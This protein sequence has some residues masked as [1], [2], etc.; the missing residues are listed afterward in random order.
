VRASDGSTARHI[1]TQ[2]DIVLGWEPVRWFNA[3][4]A[5]SAFVP[6]QFIRDTGPSRTTHFVGLEAS[7]K[8]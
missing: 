2:F 8:F 3:E 1:G 4:L 7:V 5:Y 6:G